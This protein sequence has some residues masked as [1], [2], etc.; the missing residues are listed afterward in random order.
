MTI[1]VQNPINEYLGNGSAKTFNYSFY[2][3][4]SADLKVYLNG[5]L[6]GS[7]FT[8]TGADN[9]TGGTVLFTV[10]PSSGTRVRLQRRI[11]LERSTD[12]QEAAAIPTATL[13]RDFDRLWMAAQ[14]T[15]IGT[16][17]LNLSNT[18]DAG[19]YRIVNVGD[20][21]NAQ[22]AVT[23]H[24]IETALTSPVVQAA[25]S[26]AAAHTSE[27]NGASSAAAA[28]A[29]ASE[30]ANRANIASMKADSASLSAANS[31]SSETAAANSAEA[32]AL[33]AASIVASVGDA[34]GYANAA[35]V[36]AADAS[37]SKNNAAASAVD[38]AGSASA[39]LISKNSAATS[40]TSAA[41]AATSASASEASSQAILEEIEGLIGE[42][43]AVT[44]VNG[45]S[46][47]VVVGKGDVG[48]GNVDNTS[49]ANKP[50]STATQTALNAKVASSAVGVSVASLVG[51]VVPASQLPSY[52][53]D[54]I[55]AAS[56]AALPATGE[57]GKLYVTLDDNKIWRWSGSIY[58]DMTPAA[59]GTVASV[60]GKTGVVVLV[61]GDLSLGNVD[62]TSDAN[63]PISTA[64]Q[65]ALNAKEGTIAVGTTAQYWRGDKSWQTLNATAV[66]LGNVTNTSDA[67]KPVSTA[68]QTAL[69]LKANLAGGTP[70]TGAVTISSAGSLVVSS[71]AL[72]QPVTVTYGT[73]TTINSALSNVF[74][75]ALTGNITTLTISNATDGQT[76]SIR[77]AQDATG[78]RTV[79]IPS[80]VK[81]AGAIETGAN[82][83]SV[84]T[85]TYVSAASRWEGGWNVV[86]A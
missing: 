38:S 80:S 7:G 5:V 63:K 66:G 41:N 40:A 36:S 32:S 8:V 12:Y 34:Q 23:K 4:T 77:F 42:G 10:A 45:Q 11:E 3:T 71:K 21:V 73:T 25:A 43:F 24:W 62:N 37:A 15:R 20:P 83:V 70:F 46:G 85:L 30:A 14:D 86:P 69:N 55:E 50:I 2:I 76:I 54:V 64:T 31:A 22:D 48:L 39:A 29:S 35:A 58:V 59:G 47:D 81:A 74:R 56:F 44:S 67:N 52:V 57:S 65:T 6:Q 60:N 72:T 61:K 68:Q 26:A 9:Q 1:S 33:S 18:W 51:G 27:V 82:R 78:G 16:L 84:L 13:D 19:G 79:A 17:T 53:D 49:D 28:L 75:V